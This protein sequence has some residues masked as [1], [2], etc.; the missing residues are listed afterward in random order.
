MFAKKSLSTKLYKYSW[1]TFK[2]GV[3]KE[4]P[5]EEDK[6]ES[7]GEVVLL[8]SDGEPVNSENSM[9]VVR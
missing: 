6:E 3:E 5:V 2:K 9:P 4:L 7:K 8:N 1:E